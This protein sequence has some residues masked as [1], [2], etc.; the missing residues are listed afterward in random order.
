L[1]SAELKGGEVIALSVFS[2]K[3][4]ELTLQNPWKNRPVK[5]K[6]SGGSEQTYEGEF[7]KI[8]TKL[9]TGYTFSPTP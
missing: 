2:E 9:N 3:G 1:V 5:V 7:L 6:E 4:R 8:G